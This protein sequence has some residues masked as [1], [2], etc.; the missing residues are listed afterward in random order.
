MALDPRPRTVI[1]L[2]GKSGRPAYHTRRPRKRAGSF[3]RPGRPRTPPAPQIAPWRDRQRGGPLGAIPLR[4]YRPVACRTRRPAAGAG[5]LSR[6]GW[7]IGNIES[8]MWLRS[9]GGAG[10]QRHLRAITT[11]A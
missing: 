2:I 1:D 6:G 4:V 5:V 10:D 7:V 8:T 11:G 9:D 3:S